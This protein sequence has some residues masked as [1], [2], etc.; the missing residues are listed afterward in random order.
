MSS[1]SHR[2]LFQPGDLI[3]SYIIVGLLGQGGYGDIYSVRSRDSDTLF[4]MK[5][6]SFTAEKRALD[7]ELVFLEDLQDSA[8]FPRLIESGRTETHQF[9]VQELLGP[10]VSN[11]RRQLPGRHYT[12]S[13]VLRLGLFMLECIRDFHR[14]GFVHRDIKPGN[15]LL[16]PRVGNPLVLIDFGLS[17]RHIDPET[18]KPYSPRQNAGFYGTLKY[19]SLNAHRNVEQSPADD[20]VSLLYSMIEMVDGRLPWSTDQNGFVYQKK[21]SISPRILFRSLPLEMCD[22]A[23]YLKT[24]TYQSKVN[25]DYVTCLLCQGLRKT[26]VQA[27]WPFDWE[28]LPESAMRLISAIPCLPRA[29]ECVGSIPEIGIAEHEQEA[30]N[31][32]CV[33]CEVA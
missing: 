4:A 13:T 25:Y 28:E 18:G 30:E 21:M 33:F 22:I 9:F 24:L 32:R 26:G 1:R 5:I 15:F 23:E 31:D 10:S 3:S 14:H 19:S 27:D 17:R 11:T 12:P 7:L 8:L 2:Q 29:V 6:E 20:L 16:K